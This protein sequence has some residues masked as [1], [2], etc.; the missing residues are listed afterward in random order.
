MATKRTRTVRRRPVRLSLPDDVIQIGRALADSDR[1][2]MSSM[3]EVLLVAER[4]RR[5]QSRELVPKS[6]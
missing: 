1:R 4:S 6:S 2:S 3:V 5:Q